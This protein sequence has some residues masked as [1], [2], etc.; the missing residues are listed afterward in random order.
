MDFRQI[1]RVETKMS[2]QLVFDDD[3]APQHCQVRNLSKNGARLYISAQVRL[4]AEF[5]LDIPDLGRRH[6]CRTRWRRS[7]ALGVEFMEV[8]VPA[9]AD[10]GSDFPE[11]GLDVIDQLRELE[12]ENRRLLKLLLDVCRAEG[13]RDSIALEYGVDELLIRAKAI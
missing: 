10:M 2:A 8:D 9:F 11:I 12:D 4:P 7:D 1:N 3:A 5:D 6:K 13:A